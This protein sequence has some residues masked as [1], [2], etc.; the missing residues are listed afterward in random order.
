MTHLKPV[1]EQR[2]VGCFL[3]ESPSDKFQAGSGGTAIAAER[4]LPGQE[5]RRCPQLRPGAIP[6]ADSLWR[7]TPVTAPGRRVE[8]LL[9][10]QGARNPGKPPQPD[11]PQVWMPGHLNRG[12]VSSPVEHLQN[13]AAE[14]SNIRLGGG[15]SPVAVLFHT[16]SWVRSP[17]PAPPTT[18]NRIQLVLFTF[19]ICLS[20]ATPS[21]R[22]PP[23]VTHVILICLVGPLINGKRNGWSSFQ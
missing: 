3:S 5:A 14:S 10:L 8:W 23:Q 2:V 7:A 19:W 1:E 21:H 6:P 20:G 22:E 15:C 9:G 4:A 13:S 12:G 16:N 17:P 11:T 18:N